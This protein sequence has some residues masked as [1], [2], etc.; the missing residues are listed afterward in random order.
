MTGSAYKYPADIWA[1]GLV[2]LE[3]ALGKFPFDISGVY[4]DMMQAVINGP[5]P[6]LPKAADGSYAPFSREFAHFISCCMNKDPEAR[7]T[8][9][10]LL[11]HPW[12]AK[13]KA[14]EQTRSPKQMADWMAKIK[15]KIAERARRERARAEGE[16]PD[17][18][19]SASAASSSATSSGLGARAAAAALAADASSDPFEQGYNT[20]QTGTAS[21]ASSSAGGRFNVPADAGN[22]SSFYTAKPI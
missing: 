2:L 7:S 16:D 3:C 4:L 12:I 1:I 9:D 8:A 22:K 14:P 17:A 21:G 6:S 10:E 19:P 15:P 11:L 13:A 18:L 20:T 5:S